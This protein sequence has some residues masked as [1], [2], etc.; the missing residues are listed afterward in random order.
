MRWSHIGRAVLALAVA[1]ALAA[2]GSTT[3]TST[4]T[5]TS[6]THSAS[7]HATGRV[8]PIPTF[9]LPSTAAG[10]GG[11]TTLSGGAKRIPARISEV[12]S[13][14]AAIVNV[15]IDGQGPF[16]FVVDTGAT[17]VTIA[18][19]L[20][21][22]LHLPETGKPQMF[23]GA[24]CTGESQNRRIAS[25]SLEGVPL[26]PQVVS[27]ANLPRFGGPGLPDGLLG[28]DVWNAFGAMRID[29]HAGNLIVPG[30][31]GPLPTTETIVTKPSTAPLPAALGTGRPRLSAAMHV[32][33][34]PEGTLILV[35]VAFGAHRALPFTPDTGASSSLVDSAAARQAGLSPTGVQQRN[36][37]VC[38]T[39]TLPE[40]ASGRW[41]LGGQGLIPQPVATTD[42][43]QSSPNRGL[44]GADQMSRYGSAVFDYRGGRLELGVAAR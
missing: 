21:D 1:V 39:I 16:P 27:A 34:A 24:G 36:T 32:L 42:L 5:S 4:S 23:E 41:S 31:E 22:R 35:G 13:Q 7:T 6:A 9:A 33:A 37:T 17:T 40:V 18:S 10:C 2:C 25:W 15:C 12:E 30:A 11:A 43:G 26:R 20:A 19:S 28:S 29:F 44:L 8:I 3:K 38:S 14:V